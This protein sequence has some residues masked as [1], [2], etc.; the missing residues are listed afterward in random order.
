[1]NSRL[2]NY[3]LVTTFI[4]TFVL[5]LLYIKYGSDTDILDNLNNNSIKNEKVKINNNANINEN[6]KT[7]MEELKRFLS[8]AIVM[9]SFFAGC[10]FVSLLV[11]ESDK[12]KS[13]KYVGIYFLFLIGIILFIM[14]ATILKTENI[15]EYIKGKKFTYTGLIMTISVGATIF[16]FIDNFGLKLGTEALDN[17]FL[18][19]FLGPFSRDTRFTKHRKNIRKNIETIN[20]WA[21]G[22]WRKI[23]NQVLRFKDEISRN[24]KLDDLTKSI[25]DFKCEKLNIPEDILK[26]RKETNNYV[27]NLRSQYDIID[28]SK[29]MMGNTFSNFIAAMLGA[30]ILNLFIYMTGYDGS[31]TGDQEIDDNFLVSNIATIGPVFEGIF[32][33][34]GC[35]IPIFLSIAMKRNDFNYNNKFAWLF[36]L[37]IGL[38][39]FI[40]M[41]LSVNGLKNM[42]SKDKKNS[43]K[44]SLR[45]LKR[46]LDI[47]EDKIE[48]KE[49]SI[50]MEKF[51]NSL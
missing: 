18:Y 11:I 35:L 9:F 46:R 49:I 10:Y 5:S 19:T 34:I 2:Y 4:T 24:S 37:I 6:K 8:P 50:K 7:K 31:Y 15:Q 29:A 51:I 16:G 21:A 38:F 33:V 42:T 41:Y 23:I 48:E 22:D 26:S 25:K 40:M 1:M 36:V 47:K 30:A 12:N 28:D 17:V 43:L 45:D 44:K 27:D 14:N 13:D 3:I 39:I 32:I 20:S